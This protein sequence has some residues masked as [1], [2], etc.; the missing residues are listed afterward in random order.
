MNERSGI[1]EKKSLKVNVGA[2]ITALQSNIEQVI[3]KISVT[4]E[5]LSTSMSQSEDIRAS[6]ASQ[7]SCKGTMSDEL[8]TLVVNSRQILSAAVNYLDRP[9]IDESDGVYQSKQRELIGSNQRYFQ[10]MEHHYSKAV[11]LQEKY[12][13][14]FERTEFE[15][16]AAMISI[17]Q[18]IDI[19]KQLDLSATKV[20]EMREHSK[21][22]VAY[23]EKLLVEAGTLIAQDMKSKECAIED[24]KS[25]IDAVR[26]NIATISQSE[27]VINTK[28]NSLLSKQYKSCFESTG[29]SSSIA[30]LEHLALMSNSS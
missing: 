2:Q 3:N 24:L 15:V 21:S 12:Q 19:V 4:E 30:E 29:S 20:Q 8:N 5:V 14:Q 22:L 25:A 9:E 17:A 7:R 28:L 11:T 1:D 27:K 10:D 6:V 23:F 26:Y 18:N 13:S 16:N